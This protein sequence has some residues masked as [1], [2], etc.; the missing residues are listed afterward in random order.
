[1]NR[2]MSESPVGRSRTTACPPAS[3]QRPVP[4]VMAYTLRGWSK[5]RPWRVSWSLPMRALITHS[6]VEG[7]LARRTKVHITPLMPTLR[8]SR[9]RFSLST[10]PSPRAGASLPGSWSTSLD[11]TSWPVR[12]RTVT[13]S[14]WAEAKDAK[15]RVVTTRAVRKMNAF[16]RRGM[17]TSLLVSCRSAWR[18]RERGE[19]RVARAMNCPPKLLNEHQQRYTLRDETPSVPLPSG[20]LAQWRTMAKL[21]L[22]TAADV[23]LMQGLAQRVTAIRRTW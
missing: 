18:C 11:S 23:Q 1:M 7:G 6:R 20:V 15:L 12:C 4:P 5:A 19:A 10:K 3:R 16:Q 8:P 13:L 17:A 14:V 22:V 2:V 9:S 21:E